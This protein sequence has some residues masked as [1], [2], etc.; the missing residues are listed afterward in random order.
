MSAPTPTEFVNVE[1]YYSPETGGLFFGVEPIMLV[2]ALL[3][4]LAVAALAY[5]VGSRRL[6]GKSASDEVTDRIHARILKASQA[7][8]SADSSQLKHKAEE[9]AALVAKL[10]GPV[11]KV[12][13]GVGGPLK[14]LDEALKGKIKVAASHDTTPVAYDKRDDALNGG[15]GG[16]SGGGAAA[17]S[18]VTIISLPFSVA[19]HGAHPS[20]AEPAHPPVAA[21]ASVH[22]AAPEE[23]RDMTSEEQTDALARAVRKFND[24]WSRSDA[25]RTELSEARKALSN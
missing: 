12:G 4:L 19:S 9:L 15:G 24:H 2:S 6:T 25:R 20:P 17:S 16:G 21:H 7:A 11:I 3:V 1:G 23:T 5:L 13:S 14:L 10:L 8:L 18:H 22:P